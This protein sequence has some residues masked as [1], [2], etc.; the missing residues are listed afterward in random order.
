MIL[1]LEHD[2][3]RQHTADHVNARID[4]EIEANLRRYAQASPDRIGARIEELDQEW[5][6]ERV[7]MTNA[8]SLGLLGTVLGGT[9]H[10]RF[11]A[12]PA[13]VL[14]FLLHHAIRGWCP[15]LPLLR[16]VFGLRT[17]K[18]IDVERYALKVLRG[19]FRD[20][21]RGSTDPSERVRHAL[22][23]LGPAW[24]PAR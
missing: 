23:A 12:M 1:A 24:S 22:R 9:V 13:V 18:E 11:F 19:D 3:I 5:D 15:P 21:P 14:P 2:R 10:R 4:R 16:R 8:A 6:V 7:L 20:L 17:R